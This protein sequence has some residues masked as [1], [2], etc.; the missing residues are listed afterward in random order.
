MARKKRSDVATDLRKAQRAHLRYMIRHPDFVKDLQ[1]LYTKLQGRGEPNVSVDEIGSPT[2]PAFKN[3]RRRLSIKWRVLERALDIL[4]ERPDLYDDLTR[5]D[6]FV[7]QHPFS[8][9]PVNVIQNVGEY[10]YYSQD[11]G[12]LILRLNLS[13]PRNTLVELIEKK[14]PEFIPAQKGRR[15][16]DKVD[17]QL[18]VFDLG[19][20]GRTFGLIAL[21]LGRPV[22]TVKS[23]LFAALRIIYGPRSRVSKGALA[24]EGFD[25]LRHLAKCETCKSAS[26]SDEWCDVARRFAF[27]EEKAR[28]ELPLP[29]DRLERRR[30]GGQRPRTDAESE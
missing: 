15:R 2:R 26:S 27:P 18:R 22:T 29:E 12:F 23:A 19:R 16:L 24:L 9:R 11:S 14:L 3:E 21:E 1:W 4:M 30:G 7:V 25:F 10:T 13:Y 20:A 17:F 5:L 6:E 8:Y 28:R